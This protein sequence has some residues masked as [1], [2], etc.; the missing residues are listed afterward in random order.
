[1]PNI[2]GTQ[3][4]DATLK[5]DSL[6]AQQTVSKAIGKLWQ[7]SGDH[8]RTSRAR[9]LSAFQA[10]FQDYLR[11]QVDDDAVSSL[12]PTPSPRSSPPPESDRR[13]R[14]VAGRRERQPK[15]MHNWVSL[16]HS[17]RKHSNSL[18]KK[19][20][21]IRKPQ[22]QSSQMSSDSDPHHSMVTRSRKTRSTRFYRLTLPP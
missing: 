3:I 17:R 15:Q 16:D 2:R 18:G 13:P 22:R 5:L 7:I 6:R 14:A 21:R 12:S 11:T 9:R 10:Y 1:M 20:N 4:N 8:R 19:T